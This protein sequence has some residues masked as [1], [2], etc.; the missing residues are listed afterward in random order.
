MGGAPGEIWST[1]PRS[2]E[3]LITGP[4][5]HCIKCL[6]CSVLAC[7]HYMVTTEAP[8]S[9]WSDLTKLLSCWRRCGVAGR[10]PDPHQASPGRWSNHITTTTT[11]L[12]PDHITKVFIIHLANHEEANFCVS[13]WVKSSPNFTSVR[14]KSVAYKNILIFPPFQL[15]IV[16]EKWKFQN[17]EKLY[18]HSSSILQKLKAK[19]F[20]SRII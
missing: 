9:S 16:M 20:N 14:C 10:R 2:G 19:S 11:I 15:S 8:L 18:S 3:A 6:K 4:R 12:I 7:D 17:E 13:H 1:H 5:S